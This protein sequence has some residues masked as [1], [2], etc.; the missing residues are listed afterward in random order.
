MK[1]MI[2]GAG[3]IGRGFVSELL[4]ANQVEI[5]YFDA[6]SVMVDK[7]NEKKEYTI[8]VLGAEELNTHMEG[9]QAHLFYDIDALCTC[10]K[11]ADFLFTACGG[12]NMGNVGETLAKAFKR[13]VE[14]NAVHVSNIVTCENWINPAKDLKEAIV[15][16]LNEEERKL[17]EENVGV[18]ESVIMCTGT[19][20]PDP[21]KVTNE[22]DTWVQNMRYLP[23][24]RDR[25]KGEIPQW[26]YVE[27][28]TDFGD[29]LKQ[30]IYTNNT[31]VATVS[32]LG[33]LKG[34]TYVADSANDPEIEWESMRKV[35][36]N[37]PK[38][39]KRKIQT[40]L[41]SI[42]L[43]ALPE[44]PSVSW[45]RRIALSG[46]C[47]SHCLRESGQRRLHLVLPLH[48]ILTILRTAMHFV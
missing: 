35:R 23:I 36:S 43:H 29:L 22:M 26:D 10:W 9:G 27:F 15:S 3:R 34:L 5:T 32:Y 16:N 6:S 14:E 4:H 8:H 17:F 47:V 21:D 48:C 18:S 40:A 25:I 30:K 39:Q 38:Q 20:A 19:G 2:L 24:D 45:D 37:S 46:R 41:L 31:S 7:L 42:W 1:A 13:L 11:E 44:I 12:K 28:V 33:K